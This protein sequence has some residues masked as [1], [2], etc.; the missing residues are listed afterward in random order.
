VVLFLALL[1]G[2]PWVVGRLRGD[3]VANY[4][5]SQKGWKEILETVD[6]RKETERS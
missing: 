1:V 4:A 5:V 3:S 6:K 2:G